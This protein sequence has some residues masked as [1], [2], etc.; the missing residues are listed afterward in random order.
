MCIKFEFTVSGFTTEDAKLIMDVVVNVAEML[1]A[2]V[3]G[4]F[5][6]LDED[7]YVEES[8]PEK[9]SNGG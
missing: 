8:H 9:L 4:G 3:A 7:N 6:P 2:T 1:K 5:Y